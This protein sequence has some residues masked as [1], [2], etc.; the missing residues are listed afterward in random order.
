MTEATL[1]D[2]L[3]RLRALPRADKLRAMQFL[4][5]EL[6]AEEDVT[7]L[8]SDTEHP[9]WTPYGSH[10]TATALLKFLTEEQIS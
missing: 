6:A 3:P 1:V 8:A 7:L 9:I 2:L 4:V 5:S 10:D